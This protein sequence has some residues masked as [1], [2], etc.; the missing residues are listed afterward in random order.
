MFTSSTAVVHS[1]ADDIKFALTSLAKLRASL[2]RD[3][4]GR[5]TQHFGQFGVIS[6]RNSLSTFFLAGILYFLNTSC[7][8]CARHSPTQAVK[9]STCLGTSYSS[10]PFHSS[11]HRPSP[12]RYALPES[13]SPATLPPLQS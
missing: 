2:H 11:A 8:C 12:V 10:N 6:F 7:T 4:D 13:R 3:L 9:P 5:F 1:G